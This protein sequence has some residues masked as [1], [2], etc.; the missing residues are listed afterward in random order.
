MFLVYTRYILGYTSIYFIYLY[1]LVYTRIYH[2]SHSY[3]RC[4]DSRWCNYMMHY[5]SLYWCD[6]MVLHINLELHVYY[7][8]YY[9]NYHGVTVRDR[10]SESPVCTW[11]LGTPM[12]KFRPSIST[13]LRYHDRSSSVS[14]SEFKVRYRTLNFNI[15]VHRYCRLPTI[16]SCLA[17]N[18]M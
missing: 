6:F 1:I 16:A 5:M 10:D 3:L 15:T 8:T 7:M 2:F 4:E 11:I 17:C 13:F 9:M 14:D 12:S 18:G